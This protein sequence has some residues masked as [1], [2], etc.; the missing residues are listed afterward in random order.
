M[1][2]EL[3]A[4]SAVVA[5]L[6]D[7]TTHL[8]AYGGV[9]FPLALLIES[10]VIMLLPASVALCRDVPSYRLVRR[11]MLLLGVTFTA[12]HVLVAFTP[13]YD[14]LAARA[15]G[16]PEPVREPARLGLQIMTPWTFSIAYRRF[17]QGVL[18]RFGQPRAVGVGTAV[19]LGTNALVLGAGYAAGTLPG[20]A[21]GTLAVAAGVMAEALYAAWRVRP[22]LLGPL[23]AAPPVVPPLTTARFW[24]FYLPLLVTPLFLFLAM[25]LAS[26]A[27]S[28]MP[29]AIASL[30]VWPVINGVVFTLRSAGFALN[31][32]VVAMLDRPR[33]YA[34]L[35]R[36]TFVLAAVVS[37]M[38][39]GAAATPLGAFWFSRVA[40]LPPELAAMGTTGLWLSCLLPGISALQSLYQGSLVHAH[41]T[42][43][44]T[45]SVLVFLGVTAGLLAAGMA[46]G[47][48]AGLHVALAAMVLGNA[49]Q[50]AWLWARARGP[51]HAAPALEAVPAPAGGLPLGGET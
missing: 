19:R 18:I 20:I 31:E 15:L 25:P 32:V 8:A 17:L 16:V 41:R 49:A 44:V 22:V 5:R 43:G 27:M 21:V 39:L 40:A 47:G 26:A 13:L 51:L 23:R 12:L 4:V 29:R 42:R 2:L 30:A 50:V 1:G 45:E 7:A 35:R 36:F 46:W 6:P 3:P 10:P 37:M 28:R 48:T 9:V 24:R 34:A 38:L 33:A 11:F 14:L